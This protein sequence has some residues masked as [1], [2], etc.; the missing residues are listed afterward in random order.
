MTKLAIPQKMTYVLLQDKVRCATGEM[1][2][3]YY[4]VHI[5]ENLLKKTH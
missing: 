5:D 4:N 3:H 1:C 2:H